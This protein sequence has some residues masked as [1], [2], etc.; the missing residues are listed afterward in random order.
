DGFVDDALRA[1]VIAA[2]RQRLRVRQ[3]DPAIDRGQALVLA[4][5]VVLGTALDGLVDALHIAEQADVR[6]RDVT[7]VWMARGLGRLER[8]Q[9]RVERTAQVALP[10]AVVALAN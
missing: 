10:P 9:Q 7:P 6:G 5:R 3:V 8:R 2:A 1:R 4:Q